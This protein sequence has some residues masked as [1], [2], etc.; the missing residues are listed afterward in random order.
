M[1]LGLVKGSFSLPEGA[2]APSTK[3]ARGTTT[4]NTTTDFELQSTRLANIYGYVTP[5]RDQGQ[6]GSCWAFAATAALES[7]YLMST[8]GDG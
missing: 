6:C 8:N 3:P 5:I 2:P 4:K 1:R 7:Q